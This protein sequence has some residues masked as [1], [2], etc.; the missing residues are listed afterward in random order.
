[1]NSG[2]S[3]FIGSGGQSARHRRFASCSQTSRPCVQATSPPVRLT[4][5]TCLDAAGFLERRVDIG[6]QRH[7]AAAAQ[8][9]VGGD[10]DRGFG[11]FDAAGERVGREAAE[12][13]G[14][15]RADPRAGQHRIGRLGDHRQVDGDA[16]ALL[17][18]MRLQHIG[19]AA[20]LV[21]KFGVGDVLGLRWDRR[22]PR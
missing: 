20:D 12:H 13:D 11:V 3:A 21:G 14:M 9:L 1:M 19:E 6:L 16:V 15:D 5:S 7:L 10:D 17:D 8:A 2:S 22:L 4:T 18:A